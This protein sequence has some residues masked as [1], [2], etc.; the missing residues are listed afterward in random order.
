MAVIVAYILSGCG[1]VVLDVMYEKV[2][3]KVLWPLDR[4]CR[5][6]ESHQVCG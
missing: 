2:F 4:F 5:I 3:K 6:K 1:H